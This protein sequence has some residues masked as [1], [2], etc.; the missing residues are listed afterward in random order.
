M[1]IIYRMIIK[2][3]RCNNYISVHSLFKSKKLERLKVFD[4]RYVHDSLEGKGD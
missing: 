2:V 3:K 1:D 4:R